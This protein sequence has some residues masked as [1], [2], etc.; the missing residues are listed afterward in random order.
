[1]K[2]RIAK[3][4]GKEELSHHF[5][6]GQQKLLSENRRHQAVCPPQPSLGRE[7]DLCVYPLVLICKQGTAKRREMMGRKELAFALLL[8]LLLPSVPHPGWAGGK[9]PKGGECA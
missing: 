9:P 5:V 7:R 1:M 3:E 6:W 8:L 2:G 4:E